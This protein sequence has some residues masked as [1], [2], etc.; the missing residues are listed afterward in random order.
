MRHIIK[1]CGTER[2]FNNSHSDW[3]LEEH[4]IFKDELTI[5][6]QNANNFINIFAGNFGMRHNNHDVVIKFYEKEKGGKSS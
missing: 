1:S 4:D 3:H 6:A 5:F 2:I